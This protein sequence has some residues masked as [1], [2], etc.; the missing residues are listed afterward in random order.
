MPP[1][2][3]VLILCTGNS[4]R[5]QMAEGLLR[6]GA[7]ELFEVFSAGV[8]PTQ[9]RPE[10]ITVMKELGI[11]LGSHRCKHVSEFAGQSFDY[12]LTVCDHAREACPVFPGATRSIHRGFTDP[13]SIEGNEQE[14]LA[15]FRKVRDEI[16]QYMA[17]FPNSPDK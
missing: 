10:A 6:H 12:V 16:R 1:Q 11:D 7:G 17:G 8:E 4:A 2:K 3:R 14:R 9:V 15:V 13:A 5:S